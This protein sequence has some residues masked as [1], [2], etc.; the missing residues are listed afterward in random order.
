M[1]AVI[2]NFLPNHPLGEA[3]ASLG[4]QV[5]SDQR[6][7]PSALLRDTVLCLSGM[8]MLA[9]RPIAA[10]GLYR[11][12]AAFGVPHI[13]WNRDGPSHM[14]EK[15]W[16]LSLMRNVRIMDSYATHTLQGCHGFADD[17]LYLANAAWHTRYQLGSRSL[18]SMRDRSNYEVDVSFFGELDAKRVPEMAPRVQFLNEL[19]RRLDQL[20]ITHRFTGERLTLTEQVSLIQSS[21]INLSVHAGCDTRYRGGWSGQP[22][23]WGLPERCYGIPAAGGFLLSDRRLHAAD[24]FAVGEWVDFSGIDDCVAKIR[25]Y[26]SNFSQ[27]RSIAEA[28]HI[29]VL[30]Q[31]TYVHRARR[32]LDFAQFHR[33]WVGKPIAG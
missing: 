12:L 26:L 9:K 23:S 4:Y 2:L 6:S 17:V 11:R 33:R 31:H 29:R 13:V 7:P 1:S 19:A 24:D 8:R 28:A 10:I 5:W 16:R 20:H 15:A 30:A 21:R 3:F 32:L 18:D 14:G 27:A 25:H 22:P